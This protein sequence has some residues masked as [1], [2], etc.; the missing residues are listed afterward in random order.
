MRKI[1][2]YKKV[3][4]V[5]EKRCSNLEEIQN[6]LLRELRNFKQLTCVKK[7]EIKEI[8]TI[9]NIYENSAQSPDETLLKHED[10]TTP[11]DELKHY[12][13]KLKDT[14]G[15]LINCKE[16]IKKLEITLE[17]QVETY[18]N[19][20]TEYMGQGEEY[21]KA[22]SHLENMKQLLN[23]T[24]EKQKQ[25]IEEIEVCFNIWPILCT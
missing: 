7:Y 1:Q 14:N 12:K 19:L 5:S 25:L 9:F 20:R 24:E 4:D 15:E 3:R 17:K 10:N 2:E 18:D 13:Q 21:S 23:V 11:Q 8:P 16:Y 22:L 6:R